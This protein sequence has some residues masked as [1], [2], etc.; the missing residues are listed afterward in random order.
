MDMD[1]TP[2][3]IIRDHSWQYLGSHCKLGLVTC[4][5]RTEPL[6]YQAPTKAV[7][8][9]G[10]NLKLYGDTQVKMVFKLYMYKDME[11]R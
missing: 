5:A 7:F 6:F 1:R 11:H 10:H 9:R 2:G 3:S 4:K 8:Q